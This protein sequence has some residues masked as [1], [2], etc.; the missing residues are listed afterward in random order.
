MDGVFE[1]NL[2]GVKANDGIWFTW[3]YI[4]ICFLLCQY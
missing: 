1:K 4:T 3:R 2:A